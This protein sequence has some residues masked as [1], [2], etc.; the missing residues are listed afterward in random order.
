MTKKNFFSTNIHSF[1]ELAIFKIIS[2]AY[3]IY[4][5]SLVSISFL[6]PI[7]VF[8][9]MGT[10][11]QKCPKVPINAHDK[12]IFFST[13]THSFFM[14]LVLPEAQGHVLTY[15]IAQYHVPSLSL[16]FDNLTKYVELSIFHNL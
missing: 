15:Q 10:F 6:F 7:L 4:G 9:P 1:F 14:P 11:A 16:H 5:T 8:L 13:N 12:K 3:N 2:Y